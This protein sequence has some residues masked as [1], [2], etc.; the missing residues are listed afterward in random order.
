MYQVFLDLN[1]TG[2]PNRTEVMA[3]NRPLIDGRNLTEAEDALFNIVP[4]NWLVPWE[5][6]IERQN[7]KRPPRAY[8]VGM[9]ALVCVGDHD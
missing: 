4:E 9:K 8:L 6:F 5:I 3:F 1:S 2:V 7:S